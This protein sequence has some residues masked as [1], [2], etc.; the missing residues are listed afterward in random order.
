[1]LVIPGPEELLIAGFLVKVGGKGGTKLV[2]KAVTKEV[3][4]LDTSKTTCG[5][6][7]I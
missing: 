2:S 5:N 7:S 3:S 4:K 6:C 1:M